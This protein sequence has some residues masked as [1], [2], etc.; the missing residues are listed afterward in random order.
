ME[1]ENFEQKTDFDAKTAGY[2]LPPSFINSW[3]TLML[4]AEILEVLQPGYVP[5]PNANQLRMMFGTH[6]KSVG[7]MRRI[8]SPEENAETDAYVR[9]N[10]NEKRRYFRDELAH[11]LTYDKNMFDP[12]PDVI[13]TYDAIVDE[14]NNELDKGSMTPKMTKHYATRVIDLIYGEARKPPIRL[15]N[16]GE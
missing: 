1:T 3:Y 5:S 11:V 10:L 6:E 14:Y 12:D 8:T 2:N 16:P 15:Y 13:K 4:N 7:R 9:E